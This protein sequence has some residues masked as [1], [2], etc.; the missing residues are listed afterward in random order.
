MSKYELLL[1]FYNSISDSGVDKFFPLLI[2]FDI[3]K[4][5]NKDFLFNSSLD[6]QIFE[7][8]KQE[9]ELAQTIKE[10]LAENEMPVRVSLNDL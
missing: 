1:L 8:L 9:L 6:L 5:L 3:F 10:R 7:D 4:H 2:E